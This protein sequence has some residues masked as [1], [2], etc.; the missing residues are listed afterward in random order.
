MMKRRPSSASWSRGVQAILAAACLALAGCAMEA[1][2]E[3][4][5]GAMEEGTFDEPFD[6][7]AD[8]S[9]D[10]TSM[11]ADPAESAPEDEEIAPEDQESGA[12]CVGYGGHC[13]STSACCGDMVCAFDGYARYCRN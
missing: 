10:E 9:M 4:E 11:E 6:E 5:A 1:M 13:A 7:P 12:A 3:S 8:Q 2:D